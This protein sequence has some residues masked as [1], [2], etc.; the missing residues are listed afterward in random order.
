MSQC[1][2]EGYTMFLLIFGLSNEAFKIS[3]QS[4]YKA[5]GHNSIPR[6]NDKP[7]V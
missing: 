5:L 6:R 3:I 2:C 7:N 1:E 4:F